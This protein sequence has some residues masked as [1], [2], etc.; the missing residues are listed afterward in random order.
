M[1]LLRRTGT[2]WRST[3]VLLSSMLLIF[4]LVGAAAAKPAPKVNVCHSASG[5]FHMINVSENAK[6]AHLAHG[7]YLPG[8]ARDCRTSSTTKVASGAST[9]NYS[10]GVISVAF[11]AFKTGGVYSGTGTYSYTKDGRT[12]TFA[13]AH[14]CMNKTT[15]TMTVWGPGTSNQTPYTGYGMLSLKD[16]GTSMGTRAAFGSSLASLP[17]TTQCSGSPL[18]PATGTGFLTFW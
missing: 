7:D 17:T 10:G 13:V 4:G 2:G 14:A 15:K 1:A 16:Y 8:K 9:S 3:I 18:F 11:T 12:Y 6:A 5:T